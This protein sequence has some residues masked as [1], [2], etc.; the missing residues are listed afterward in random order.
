MRSLLN[1]NNS[2]L[3]LTFA[4]Y[5]ENSFYWVAE[6]QQD[7]WIYFCKLNKKSQKKKQE[8]TTVYVHILYYIV[9]VQCLLYN[10]KEYSFCYCF[11][12]SEF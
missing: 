7:V 4:S 10:I 12:L 8:K 5:F 11:L 1:L 9:Y 6:S 2:A 3:I